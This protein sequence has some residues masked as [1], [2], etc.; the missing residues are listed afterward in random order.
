MQKD[1]SKLTVACRN[2]ANAPKQR[3]HRFR[4]DNP[5]F[6]PV[7]V[8]P[9]I[10]YDNFCLNTTVIRRTSD[11]RLETFNQSHTLRSSGGNG[12][13]GMLTMFQFLLF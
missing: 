13:N 10:L 1:R 9:A 12:Q 4:F 3:W 7:T 2:F 11:R 6:P 8:I 5:G